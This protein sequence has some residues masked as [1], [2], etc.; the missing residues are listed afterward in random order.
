MK[1]IHGMLFC[2]GVL[3]LMIA[4]TGAHANSHGV[5]QSQQDRG[6]AGE[7]VKA[8]LDALL[9][10][11]R[12]NPDTQDQYYIT[13]RYTHWFVIASR[14]YS[15]SLIP[16]SSERPGTPSYYWT[17]RVN[18]ADGDSILGQL[19]QLHSQDP[20]QSLPDIE[21]QVRIKTWVLDPKTCP[22]ISLQAGKFLHQSF[23]APFSLDFTTDTPSFELRASSLNTNMTLT[24]GDRT[25]P[26][27]SWAR[28]TRRILA[29]CGA[30]ESAPSKQDP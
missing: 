23:K 4:G 20:N 12:P 30:P 11:D 26:L 16:H 17:A 25:Y 15:F 28:E 1:L 29:Q 8:A 6:W 27:V 7:N 21:R 13:Y 5:E 24:F 2:F 19:A 10:M 9:P 3:T 18:L 14:E 22:A